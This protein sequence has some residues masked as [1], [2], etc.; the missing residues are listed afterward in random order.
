MRMSLVLMAVILAGSAPVLAGNVGASGGGGSGGASAG[1]GGG[2]FS[3]GGSGGRGGGGYGG[4]GRSGGG[5]AHGGFGGGGCY[6]LLG[7]PFVQ[8][9]DRSCEGAIKSKGG[10]GTRI[11]TGARL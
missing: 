9:A 5:Y 8:G 3:G 4:G 11:G 10:S 1:G 7:A 6:R 2:G